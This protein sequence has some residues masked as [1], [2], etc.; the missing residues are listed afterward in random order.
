MLVCIYC[1]CAFLSFCDCRVDF[2]V[3]H[4][5]SCELV[6]FLRGIAICKS[7]YYYAGLQNTHWRLFLA[8][9][10]S[11]HQARKQNKN[12]VFKNKAQLRSQHTHFK[13]TYLHHWWSWKPPSWPRSPWRWGSTCLVQWPPQGTGTLWGRCC[14]GRD[15]QVAVITVILNARCFTCCISQLRRGWPWGKKS[16]SRAILPQLRRGWPWGKR[17][18]QELFWH[19]WGGGDHGEREFFKSYFD[20]A[21]EGWPW[22][23]RGRGCLL[24]FSPK[25]KMT[26]LQT[27][28]KKSNHTKLY[29]LQWQWGYLLSFWSRKRWHCCGI[30]RRKLNY[31]QLYLL[32]IWSGC[33]EKKRK[34]KREIV[35]IAYKHPIQDGYQGAVMVAHMFPKSQH[36]PSHHGPNCEV[37]GHTGTETLELQSTKQKDL[38]FPWCLCGTPGPA[39]DT[40]RQLWP[41]NNNS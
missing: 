32:N 36:T 9:L 10:S 3:D 27:C 16:S 5:Q 28:A 41:K 24:D 8:C 26:T 14:T 21:E 12:S 25:K 1:T 22:G 30:A 4:V 31:T 38:I 35:F 6:D 11:Y 13:L 23:K 15:A 18:L 7:Y 37:G 33:F 39:P 17:V 2:D 19:S 34:K 40:Q 29:L 20:T